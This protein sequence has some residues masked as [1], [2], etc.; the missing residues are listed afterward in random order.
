MNKLSM[1]LCVIFSATSSA[2]AQTGDS[3]SAN[4]LSKED[5]QAVRKTIASVE[6][7]WNAHDMKAM[8]RLFTEDAEFINV[9]GMH[10]RGR[11]DIVA[12]HEAYHKTS[13][14]NHRMK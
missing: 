10:W 6:E 5:D 1:A 4:A 14:K 9:V 7:A 8:G 12:A 2:S 13:F 3:A 11:D